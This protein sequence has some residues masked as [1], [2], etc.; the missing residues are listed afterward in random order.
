[1]DK[2]VV[3]ETYYN[4]IEA[5]IIKSRLMDSGVQCF[6]SDENMITIN[7][8]YTQALGGIK[9]HLFEKDVN[10]ARSILQ[11]E[12][13]Q[14]ALGEATVDVPES[15]NG[16][17]Q[18]DQVCPNCGSSN[19]GYV[20]ATKKRFSILTMIVSILLLVYPFAAKKTNHCFDCGYEFE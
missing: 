1:M 2:I 6:L 19:V 18:N 14:I 12:D 7:P 8:L 20:Q 16:D 15:Q 4:P 13:V 11:D 10:T 9:L 5:N 17:I 3:F